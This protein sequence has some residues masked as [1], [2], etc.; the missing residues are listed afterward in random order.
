MLFTCRRFCHH[1][2][3]ARTGLVIFRT[4]KASSGMALEAFPPCS[5]L[6]CLAVNASEIAVFV[7]AAGDEAQLVLRRLT[8]N[9]SSRISCDPKLPLG[10]AASENATFSAAGD[11]LLLQCDAGVAVIDIPEIEALQEWPA[12]LSAR[13]AQRTR[14]AR[15]R[16]NQP[17]AAAMTLDWTPYPTLESETQSGIQ[18]HRMLFVS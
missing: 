1:W 4:V 18:L 6:S 11:Q 8:D 7:V 2:P 15:A 10:F 5:K 9:Q 16:L 17:I 3:L 13:Y 12:E 14:H